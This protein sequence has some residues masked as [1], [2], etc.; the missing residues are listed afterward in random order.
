LTEESLRQFGLTDNNRKFSRPSVRIP[1]LDKEGKEVATRWRINLEGRRDKFQ[2]NKGDKPCLYGLPQLTAGESVTIVEGESDCFTLWSKGF[3]AL[4][5]PGCGNWNEERDAPHFDGFARIYVVIERDGGGDSVLG[6]LRK[7]RI[8]DRALLIAMPANT[9]DPAALYQAAPHEFAAAWTKLCAEAVPWSA[10]SMR[11]EFE[12]R[13]AAKLKAQRL[14]KLP[15]IL[16]EVSNFCHRHLA[17]TGE[18]KLV[19][20]TYLI[21]TT[22]I[23]D[24][25]VSMIVKGPSATGKSYVIKQVVQLFPAEAA[26]TRT[27]SS[28]RSIIYSD[29]PLSHRMLIFYEAAGMESDFLMYIIRSLLSEGHIIYE[30]TE[31][32]DDGEIRSRLIEREGPTGLIITTT[33]IAW[34]PENETRVISIT[35]DDSPE[36]TAAIMRAQGQQAAQ[37]RPAMPD[38]SEW[39]ALQTYISL[40]RTQV[41]IPFSSQ[42]SNMIS[43]V[44]VRLRRD[45]PAVLALIEAHAVLHQELRQR[46][47]D[48]NIIATID[49]DY[50]IVRELVK[51]LIAVGTGVKVA[52]RVRETV[53]AVADVLDTV[54]NARNEGTSVINL[55]DVPEDNTVTVKQ[56]A[57]KLKL[58]HN[59]TWRRVQDS[60]RV[61][62]L[63]NLEERKGRPARLVLGDA[64]E[65]V[66]VE[67]LPEAKALIEA[68]NADAQNVDVSPTPSGISGSALEG[69]LARKQDPQETVPPVLVVPPKPQS[70]EERLAYLKARYMARFKNQTG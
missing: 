32:G 14:L 33:K 23:L 62:V 18:R 49:D 12:R 50:A 66:E 52:D 31:K 34:H 63:R 69:S 13:E 25:I 54:K 68:L 39:H 26:M 47:H 59:P 28:E 58:D 55:A 38:L 37:G 67:L 17:V 64:I 8:A 61:G 45:F 3:Q 5:L 46:D 40:S 7:S 53:K 11:E 51:D 9:K 6:W 15:D 70:R 2:W 16:S 27:S 19:Q 20:L 43:P 22:R 65:A 36:Q 44:A 29:E 35:A 1:Y 48:G 42:L 57:K 60:I 41:V 10:H 24:Q 56:V 21:A 4:G 30:T